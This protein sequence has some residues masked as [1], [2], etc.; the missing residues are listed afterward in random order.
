M[1]V[2]RTLS[3]PLRPGAGLFEQAHDDPRCSQGEKLTRRSC[4]QRQNRPFL[5]ATV[6][7]HVDRDSAVGEKCEW[8]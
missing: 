7:N 8:R 1:T 4:Q 2:A 3:L 6:R 5:T